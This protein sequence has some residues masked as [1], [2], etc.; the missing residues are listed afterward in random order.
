MR[1]Y[2]GTFGYLFNTSALL[3]TNFNL[4][5]L[6][7][8]ES[9][10]NTKETFR[11][12]NITLLSA[13]GTKK[14]EWQTTSPNI[15]QLTSTDQL[16]TALFSANKQTN[17]KQTTNTSE[18][19]SLKKSTDLKEGVK[20]QNV[21]AK[22]QSLPPKSSSVI[23]LRVQ[24]SPIPRAA[25][26]ERQTSSSRQKPAI[27]AKETPTLHLAQKTDKTGTLP[28]R[29]SQGHPGLPN[30][31]RWMTSSLNYN[32]QSTNAMPL[33]EPRASSS[34]RKDGLL[35]KLTPLVISEDFP[36]AQPSRGSRLPQKQFEDNSF[37]KSI[38]KSLES[39]SVV[40]WRL[41]LKPATSPKLRTEQYATVPTPSATPFH[42]ASSEPSRS[43]AGPTGAL[44]DS[45]EGAKK[46]SLEGESANKTASPGEKKVRKRRSG[47]LTKP[48]KL[49]PW[50]KRSK[51]P[52]RNSGG[53]SWKSEGFVAKVHLNVSL[54]LVL[55]FSSHSP[56]SL[57]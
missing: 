49:I 56:L 44:I 22:S 2:F 14:D 55:V 12:T 11:N 1:R 37:S 5:L 28:G 54:F 24:K 20:S 16:D 38:E 36:E 57:E 39:E 31:L 33:K 50:S 4:L 43:K 23:P 8:V 18:N 46:S 27:E 7:V 32:S 25:T 30:G 42:Q 19:S 17:I 13:P 48:V 15:Q 45:D 21:A 51:E 10:S 41:Q 6:Q 34:W 29:I 9:S 47:I 3:V 26:L 35:N 53:W 52:P 40:R